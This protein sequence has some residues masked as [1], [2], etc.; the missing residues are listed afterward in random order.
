MRFLFYLLTIA[1]FLSSCNTDPVKV[2]VDKEL[3]GKDTSFTIIFDGKDTFS[4]SDNKK[5]V[6]LKPGK[7]TFT[8]KGTPAKEFT[9]GD[10]GGILNID[11]QEYVAFEIEYSSTSVKGLKGFSMNDMSVKSVILIDSFIIAPKHGITDIAD[12]SLRKVLPELQKAKNGNYYAFGHGSSAGSDYDVNDN[13]FGLKKFGKG[14][15]F[16]NKFWDYNPGED[17]PKTIE[18]RTTTPGLGSTTKSAVM[19]ASMFLLLARLS[20]EVYT[21]KTIEEVKAGRDDA[22]K[23]KEKEEKQMKF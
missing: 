19:D 8:L 21:V 6:N 7:H 23:D 9:V 10:K 16:V 14:R 22:E 3:A 11:D 18:M 5:I 13:V 2:Y 4:I 20:P 17:I 15:L 12:S 1:L